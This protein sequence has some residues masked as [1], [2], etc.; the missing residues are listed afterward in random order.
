MNIEYLN[1]FVVLADICKYQE[2]ADALYISLPTLS[3]HI[4]KMEKELG[5]PLFDR[6]TRN[7]RLTEFGNVFYTYAL[8]IS[9]SY[10]DCIDALHR[11]R[12]N[13]NDYLS[14]GFLPVLSQYGVIE[15]LS[16]FT[17]LNPNVKLSMTESEQPLDL[18]ASKRCDF[19]FD[20]EYDPTQSKYCKQLCKV[21]TLA[22]ILPLDHPLAPRGY[23][24][25]EQLS[26]ERFI[27]SHKGIPLLSDLT[28][29]CKAHGYH[30]NIASTVSFS[31]TIVKMVN[32][33]MG[34]AIMNKQHIPDSKK[35][36]V[37]VLDIQPMI[38]FSIYIYYDNSRQR[39]TAAQQ[40][41]DYFVANAQNFLKEEIHVMD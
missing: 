39:S 9:N 36:K 15:L 14:I 17:E 22:A 38:P 13:A 5:V 31:S 24:T 6:T 11:Q 16:N 41:Y 32:Q 18:L 19:V 12:I 7:V 21:D 4:A 37:A 20:A 30:P 1:E 10:N 23:V 26:N 29:L 35:Y 33:G 28:K 25:L 2:A 27:M 40:F 34:I 8:H 3:K